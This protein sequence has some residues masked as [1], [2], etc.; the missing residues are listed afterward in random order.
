MINL[1]TFFIS[2][3]VGVD[4]TPGVKRKEKLDVKKTRS[5]ETTEIN[6]FLLNA[7]KTVNKYKAEAVW[8]RVDL[9]AVRTGVTPTFKVS[10][11]NSAEQD[12]KWERIG[13]VIIREPGM[14]GRLSP[15][16]KTENILVELSLVSE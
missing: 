2:C 15:E 6:E 3:V 4:A 9:M 13:T 14:Y 16:S 12:G 8:I 11:K 1:F 5:M 10:T 7:V